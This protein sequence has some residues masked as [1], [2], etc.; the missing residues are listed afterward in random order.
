MTTPRERYIAAIAAHRQA[1]EDMHAAEAAFRNLGRRQSAAMNELDAAQ[2][3]LLQAVAE[4]REN[5]PTGT[6]INQSDQE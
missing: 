4:G 2:Y 5:E 3:E 6:P 1:V